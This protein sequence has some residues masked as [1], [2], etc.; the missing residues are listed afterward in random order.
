MQICKRLDRKT[1]DHLKI[2]KWLIDEERLKNLE[3]ST[4]ESLLGD[5]LSSNYLTAI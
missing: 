4:M 3:E 1:C 5:D 2:E